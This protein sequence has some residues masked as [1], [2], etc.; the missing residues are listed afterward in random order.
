[1]QQDI[2]SNSL[3]Q[4]LYNFSVTCHEN[5]LREKASYSSYNL[6]PGT[7]LV[8]ALQLRQ[9]T[10]QQVISRLNCSINIQVL[11]IT[12][13]GLQLSFLKVV[14]ALTSSQDSFDSPKKMRE[15]LILAWVCSITHQLDSQHHSCFIASQLA[16]HLRFLFRMPQIYPC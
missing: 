8:L 11:R 3:H 14:A 16:F 10:D 6:Q 4:Y 5:L 9:C 2:G 12:R 15:K 7:L 13:I 1:M